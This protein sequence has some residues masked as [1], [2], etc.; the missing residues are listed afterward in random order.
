MT[1]PEIAPPDRTAL[2]RGAAM[3][4]LRALVASVGLLALLAGLLWIGQ[5]TGM[6]MWP[7]QSFML[8]DP[9]WAWNGLFV[10][11][12]GIAAIWFARRG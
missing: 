10:A 8:G 1:E 4:A 7:R 2:A 12:G 5:G 9:Q 3:V 6:V 11:L